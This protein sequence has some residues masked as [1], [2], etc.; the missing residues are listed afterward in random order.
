MKENTDKV[1]KWILESEGGYSN[2]PKDPGKATNHGITQKTYNSYQENLNETNENKV[3]ENVKNITIEEVLD[4]YK[5]QYMIPIQFN[6][7][8][9]GIDYVVL[10]YAINSG[11]RRAVKTLQQIVNTTQDG[12]IGLHTLAA[13][14]SLNPTQI[15][16]EYTTKRL[17]FLKKLKTFKYFG[18][19]WTK[20]VMNVQQKS[21]SVSEET[22]FYRPYGQGPSSILSPKRLSPKRL[23]LCL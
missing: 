16:K 11:V 17:N 5:K 20:R 6:Q 23:T 1:L 19:G 3:N 7:L 12:I 9:S 22:T 2:H 18:P 15:I 4:I 14:K 13:L 8:P 10:D 21:L